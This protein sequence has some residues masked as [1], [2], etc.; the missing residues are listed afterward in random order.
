MDRKLI[1][2]LV[3][4]LTVVFTFLIAQYGCNPFSD[5]PVQA[6]Y[7]RFSSDELKLVVKDGEEKIYYYLPKL[8]EHEVIAVDLL[9]FIDL[10]PNATYQKDSLRFTLVLGDEADSDKLDLIES[11]PLAGR[12]T[13]SGQ[14]PATITVA[15]SDGS[16]LSAQL[17]VRPYKEKVEEHYDDVF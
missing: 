10:D 16:S 1:V 8:G 6:T 7:L 12:L 4:V 9:K 5:N 3:V 11:G 14:A 2:L 17:L 13:I 15:T